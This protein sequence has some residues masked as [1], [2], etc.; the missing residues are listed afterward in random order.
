M[1]SLFRVS[2]NQT[3]NDDRWEKDSQLMSSFLNCS[4][5]NTCLAFLSTNLRQLDISSWQLSLQLSVELLL[6]AGFDWSLDFTKALDWEASKGRLE[7]EEYGEINLVSAESGGTFS[8][9]G[10]FVIVGASS[11]RSRHSWHAWRSSREDWYESCEERRGVAAAT[12]SG[13]LYLVYISNII[14]HVFSQISHL[15]IFRKSKH[16]CNCL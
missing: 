14:L 11:S 8:L 1:S 5:P 15:R 10:A 6:K 4:L 3:W 12:R 9:A 13:T 7:G 16:S 2:P